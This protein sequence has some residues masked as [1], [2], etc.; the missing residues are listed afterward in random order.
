MYYYFLLYYIIFYSIILSSILF[1]YII[2]YSKKA[3]ATAPVTSNQMG[4][5]STKLFKEKPGVLTLSTTTAGIIPSHSNIPNN[6]MNKT[7]GKVATSGLNDSN[8]NNNPNN[9]K[10]NNEQLDTS[11][12]LTQEE[13]NSLEQ[14]E[15]QNNYDDV[16]DHNS[17]RHSLS[18]NYSDE[19]E[20]TSMTEIK[21][22]ASTATIVRMASNN[23]ER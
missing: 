2:L 7:K 14:Q 16:D 8:C 17:E 10:L 9:I 13:F 20:Y 22:R 21:E 12:S 3:N 23:L 5:T 19:T 6:Y 4:Q 11:I 15:N 18:S 1:Y